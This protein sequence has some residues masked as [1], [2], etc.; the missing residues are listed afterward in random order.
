MLLAVILKLFSLSTEDFYAS[1]LL[2]IP[3]TKNVR[4]QGS[5]PLKF[6]VL[7]LY[8]SCTIVPVHAPSKQHDI[9]TKQKTKQ[10]E[11]KQPTKIPRGRLQNILSCFTKRM[12]KAQKDTR[13]RLSRDIFLVVS[14]GLQL[15]SRSSVKA[16]SLR[17]T[18]K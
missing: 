8:L 7:S 9:K 14:T 11:N 10:N 6:S 1:V 4:S 5:K 12:N 16:K 13:N 18:N 2:E 15:L 3:S 17:G